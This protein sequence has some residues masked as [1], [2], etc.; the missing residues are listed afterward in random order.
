MPDPIPND[1]LN[2]LLAGD[3]AIQYQVYRDLLD[4]DRPDLRAR[5]ATEGWGAQFLV[6]RQ[7]AGH[8]G[9]G[10]YQPKWISTHYTLLDLK[11]L[12]IEPDQATIRASISHILA[13]HKSADGGVNPAKTIEN[14]DICVNGMF[15]NYAAYF[16][17]PAESLHAIVD[18]LIGAQMT[19]GGFNCQS[20]QQGAVHS[21][22]HS[23]LSVLE[24]IAEYL[25]QGYP[26]RAAELGSIARQAQEFILLHRL[27]RSDRTGAVINPRF[28][29]LSYPSRWFYDTLRA[30]DY[31]RSVGAAYDP[32]MQDALDV[33][34]QK[35]RKDGTWSLQAKH[36]GQTHFDMESPGQPS[37]WNTL[38]ALRV[39]RH[40]GFTA[41]SQTVL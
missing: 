3:V 1:L 23:T 18:F 19:D 5:I 41:S 39:L 2:W 12:G 21:S 6:A 11:H 17:M 27:Y 15:L 30:L 13:H 36:S 16:R 7:P 33:L 29:M 24:G 14:S 31:F 10:F 35:R 40:F 9:R 32:R 26:Y 37:R 38:R 28:L 4:E 20:N 25:A 8:W 22:L 34:R